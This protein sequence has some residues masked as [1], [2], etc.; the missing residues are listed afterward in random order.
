MCIVRGTNERTT[1]NW[2]IND[3]LNMELYICSFGFGLECGSM[4]WELSCSWNWVLDC[5]KHKLQLQY[6][7]RAEKF[8]YGENADPAPGNNEPTSLKNISSTNWATLETSLKKNI[9][10]L[11]KTVFTFFPP[12]SKA[13]GN[14]S[15]TDL[16]IL[17]WKSISVSHPVLLHIKYSNS[18]A[19]VWCI[20]LTSISLQ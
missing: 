5:F 16:I 19:F 3:F 4:R 7:L 8:Y 14:K 9:N 18:I 20:D 2:N 6:S 10:K 12:Y 13:V 1:E 17:E 15:S 11:K